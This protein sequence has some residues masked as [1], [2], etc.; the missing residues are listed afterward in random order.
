VTYWNVGNVLQSGNSLVQLDAALAGTNQGRLNL[1]GG[2]LHVEGGPTRTGI[3]T[4]GPLALQ[5]A[6][7]GGSGGVNVT[8]GIT[9]SGLLTAN[10]G[11]KGT[12]LLFAAL[13]AASAN[14]DVEYIVSD[15][16]N[17]PKVKSDGTNWRNLYDGTILT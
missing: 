10:G 3:R 16:T 12:A 4:F 8:G 15:R 14:T 9:A 17:R 7:L 5:P 1:G 13:P 2:Y 6:A 11:E